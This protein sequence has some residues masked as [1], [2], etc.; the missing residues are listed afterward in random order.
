[1]ADMAQQQRIESLVQEIGK[2][3]GLDDYAAT[4]S[5]HLVVGFRKMKE[6]FMILFM[7]IAMM[8]MSSWAMDRFK[9]YEHLCPVLSCQNN[10]ARIGFVLN[11]TVVTDK[12]VSF[13]CSFGHSE[14]ARCN[15][16]GYTN[17]GE[18][19]IL[20]T[21]VHLKW[22]YDMFDAALIVALI[23]G[24]IWKLQDA[25]KTIVQSV[26][27]AIALVFVL[28]QLKKSLSSLQQLR[29]IATPSFH[30]P[31]T[32]RETARLLRHDPE[33]LAQ[34]CPT[35]HMPAESDTNV[36]SVLEQL[37]V[38]MEENDVRCFHIS[39]FA[40]VADTWLK[41]NANT[42]AIAQRTLD[43]CIQKINE[44]VAPPMVVNG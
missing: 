20:I 25:S 31:W 18:S 30:F 23:L 10:V 29:A 11:G 9:H 2:A 7:I 39:T 38:A 6:S 21:D 8:Y 28:R 33:T 14:Y 26:K 3:N 22:Y 37:L 35:R 1:M 16:E 4:I 13:T 40:L 36:T 41:R 32:L 5:N 44:A 15:I 19:P 12:H 24:V 27:N 34:Y 42:T 43:R 17:H